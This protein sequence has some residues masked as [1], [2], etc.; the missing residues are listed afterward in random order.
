MRKEIFPGLAD[1]IIIMGNFNQL[2]KV[3]HPWSNM[4]LDYVT[5]SSRSN[6][7]HSERGYGSWRRFQRR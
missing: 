2:Y 5:N 7:L 4:F 6:P 1:D 3:G